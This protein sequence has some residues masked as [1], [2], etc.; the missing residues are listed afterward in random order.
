MDNPDIK[1]K[2][3]ILKDLTFINEVGV[4]ETLNSVGVNGK[5]LVS[6]SSEVWTGFDYFTGTD[7]VITSISEGINDLLHKVKEISCVSNF[8]IPVFLLADIVNPK[9]Y[10]L[11]ASLGINGVMSLK[12]NNNVFVDIFYACLMKER[13]YGPYVMRKIDDEFPAL[14]S[15]AETDLVFDILEGKRITDIARERGRNIKT[16]STQKSSIMK[17]LN[18]KNNSELSALGGLLSDFSSDC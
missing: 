6:I 13:K 14:F 16:I 3:V 15:P 5:G 1:Y 10:G 17:R 7:L 4:R 18:I 2:S 12:E 8:G 9:L 11:L